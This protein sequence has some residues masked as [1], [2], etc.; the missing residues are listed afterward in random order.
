[1][2]AV[3]FSPDSLRLAYGTADA[4]IYLWNVPAQLPLPIITIHSGGVLSLAFSPDGK[5]L[6]SGS[7]DE[8]VRFTCQIDQ[9][10]LTRLANTDPDPRKRPEDNYWIPFVQ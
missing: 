3:A 7:N 5:C 1:M 10:F 8:T 2:N 6:A 4:K 9:G